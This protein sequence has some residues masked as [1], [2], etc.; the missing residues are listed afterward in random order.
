MLIEANFPKYLWGEALRTATFLINRISTAALDGKTPYEAWYGHKPDVSKL[1]I[2]GSNAWVHI[3]KEKRTKL[4]VTSYL[5]FMLG[6]EENSYR[7]WDPATRKVVNSRDVK[8]N[9][10]DERWSL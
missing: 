6:Y 10:V 8:F 9:E 2:F 1:R 4:D 5:T 7:L 3:P